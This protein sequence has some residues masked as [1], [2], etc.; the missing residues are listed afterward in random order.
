MKTQTV[1]LPNID[2]RS[3]RPWT[4]RDVPP[5]KLA[6]KDMGVC[7]YARGEIRVRSTLKQYERVMTCIHEVVHA[8]APYLEDDAVTGIEVGV[9]SILEILC[10][11]AVGKQKPTIPDRVTERPPDRQG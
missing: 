7:D 10:G 4:L 1:I 9:M 6:K 8:V 5:S 2:I 11:D 3:M